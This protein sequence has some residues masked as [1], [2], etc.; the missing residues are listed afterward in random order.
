MWKPTVLLPAPA[1][2]LQKVEMEI[3]EQKRPRI[4]VNMQETKLEG[5]SCF[6]P[7]AIAEAEIS[8][9][10]ILSE[11]TGN[12]CHSICLAAAVSGPLG[13]K[14][15]PSLTQQMLFTASIA[16]DCR[17]GL[18][19]GGGAPVGS[20]LSTMLCPAP[21]EVDIC[22]CLTWSCSISPI[23]RRTSRPLP[24]TA[25]RGAPSE[26]LLAWGGEPNPGCPELS[27][28]QHPLQGSLQGYLAWPVTLPL[29]RYF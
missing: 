4:S 5:D 12:I 29:K 20:L 15:S 18:R 25:P 17:E 7:S 14:H 6:S 22:C 19:C 28:P 1:S 16:G 24:T 21:R 2:N 10:S 3:R 9:D 11:K 8:R 27:P 26:R 13:W 23:R